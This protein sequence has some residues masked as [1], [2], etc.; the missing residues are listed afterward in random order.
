MVSKEWGYTRLGPASRSTTGA[1][2]GAVEP[3]WLTAVAVFMD[4]LKDL[5]VI[6]RVPEFDKV[7]VR[8]VRRRGLK[9]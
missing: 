1:G 3:A 4:R 9:F 5:S 7:V 2:R 6:T 8:P